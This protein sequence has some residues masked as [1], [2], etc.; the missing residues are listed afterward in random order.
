[1]K[2]TADEI[3]MA[4]SD[5]SEQLVR[6]SIEGSSGMKEHFRSRITTW[7]ACG[8]LFVTGGIIA[9]VMSLGIGTGHGNVPGNTVDGGVT[10]SASSDSVSDDDTDTDAVTSDIGAAETTETTEITET[11]DTS[12]IAYETSAV[13]QVLSA[14]SV[15]VNSQYLNDEE[16]S[17]LC[18]ELGRGGNDGTYPVMT[19]DEYRELMWKYR[20]MGDSSP[21]TVYPTLD[22]IDDLIIY[23]RSPGEGVKWSVDSVIYDE[24]TNTLTVPLTVEC[25]DGDRIKNIVD[26]ISGADTGYLLSVDVKEQLLPLLEGGVKINAS[27]DTVTDVGSGVKINASVETVTNVESY[28]ASSKELKFEIYSHHAEVTGYYGYIGGNVT[29]PDTACGKPVTVI[30]DGVLDGVERL[31]AKAG[32]SAETLARAFAVEHR[33]I[34][35]ELDS[36]KAPDHYYPPYVQNGGFGIRDTSGDRWIAEDDDGRISEL[37]AAVMAGGKADDELVE[38]MLFRYLCIL[39]TVGWTDMLGDNIDYYTYGGVDATYGYSPPT[40][41][42]RYSVYSSDHAPYWYDAYAERFAYGSLDTY[43]EVNDY[44]HSL[45]TDNIADSYMNGQFV[46]IDG[47]AYKRQNQAGGLG[48]PVTASYDVFADGIKLI[49]REYLDSYDDYGVTFDEPYRDYVFI[50]EDG[51]WKMT[52]D[53]RYRLDLVF[54]EYQYTAYY[55]LLAEKNGEKPDDFFSLSENARNKTLYADLFTSDR[56]EDGKYL[57]RLWNYINAPEEE[58]YSYEKYESEHLPKLRE[59]LIAKIG[60][61]NV[62]VPDKKTGRTPYEQAKI[63]DWNEHVTRMYEK[64]RELCRQWADNIIDKY[65]TDK[66]DVVYIGAD[67]AEIILYAT[68]EE[69]EKY[70][71]VDDILS[72]NAVHGWGVYT[73]P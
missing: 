36:D 26:I 2:I 38:R 45:Y 55:K 31:F 29:I 73:Q 52:S 41:K 57:V 9:L 72:I 50:C 58:E 44:I 70:A 33:L 40:D 14:Q 28:E 15:M 11:T 35:I 27:A 18:A 66:N 42:D 47:M 43:D 46:N 10:P 16:Y 53:Y 5:V 22:Y 71:A 59:E 17:V 21:S 39:Q 6:E 8:A 24:T 48:S 54:D 3:I 19:A 34:F 30:R 23:V 7:A 65:V 32:T 13:Q 1:M 68:P 4:M 69:I 51:R 64:E 56:R 60:E 61:R 63:D 37:F 25:T 49:L 67:D 12:G 62:D 20:F